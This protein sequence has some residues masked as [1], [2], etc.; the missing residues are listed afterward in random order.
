MSSSL[1]GA[2]AV[3]GQDACDMCQNWE[4]SFYTPPPLVGGGVQNRSSEC[5]KTNLRDNLSGE[6]SDVLA[7]NNDNNT[8]LS[9]VVLLS[10]LWMVI[11]FITSCSLGWTCE[12]RRQGQRLPDSIICRTLF[13]FRQQIT[14]QMN[15]KRKTS[16][17]YNVKQEKKQNKRKH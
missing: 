2:A 11:M 15:M 1:G 7:D 6:V 14:K 17:W 13:C 16:K 9:R 5:G 3:S 4:R 10:L 12:G 8:I